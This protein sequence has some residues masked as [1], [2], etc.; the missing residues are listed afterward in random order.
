MI[1]MCRIFSANA[2]QKFPHLSLLSASTQSEHLFVVVLKLVLCLY[3]WPQ[4]L[5][6]AAIIHVPLT[7]Q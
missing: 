2:K 5:C 4:L 6:S 7:P 3:S 1:S